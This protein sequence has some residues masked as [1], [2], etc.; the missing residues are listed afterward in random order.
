MFQV[1]WHP[2]ALNELANL[3]LTADSSLRKDIRESTNRIEAELRRRP[4]DIG[5]SRSDDD[6]VYFDSP[7]GIVYYASSLDRRVVILHVW[8]THS[9]R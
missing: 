2:S 9:K 6:R 8:D 5:E 7:L 1:I 4:T 3:W